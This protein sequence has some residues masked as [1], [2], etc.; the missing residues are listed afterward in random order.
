MMLNACVKGFWDILVPGHRGCL[1]CARKSC[2]TMWECSESDS[3]NIMPRARKEGVEGS[4]RFEM[5]LGIF[6]YVLSSYFPLNVQENLDHTVTRQ[7]HKVK[8]HD[9]D[10][11][12]RGVPQ[13]SHCYGWDAWDALRQRSSI[14]CPHQVGAPGWKLLGTFSSRIAGDGQVSEKKAWVLVGIE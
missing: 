8:K 11:I 9:R 4:G 2:S 3:D 10:C 1:E 13:L 12:R 6:P 14:H 5:Y 7:F